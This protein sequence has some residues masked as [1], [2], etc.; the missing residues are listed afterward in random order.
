MAIEY[1]GSGAWPVEWQKVGAVPYQLII[2]MPEHDW[3][4][5][6]QLGGTFL[7][8]LVLVTLA[9]WKWASLAWSAV[10][11]LFVA[12]ALCISMSLTIDF[13][14]QRFEP[15]IPKLNQP[16]LAGLAMTPEDLERFEAAMCKMDSFPSDMLATCA[17]RNPEKHCGPIDSFLSACQ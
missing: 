13:G 1:G 11:G 12:L 4:A 6:A 3:H 5:L 9:A 7:L 15:A 2:T 17:R 16:D 8:V 10:I 14:P